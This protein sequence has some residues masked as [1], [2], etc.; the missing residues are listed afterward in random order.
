MSDVFVRTIVLKIYNPSK[1]KKEIL[2]EAMLNYTKAYQYI[3][4]MA[5]NN[6]KFIREKCKDSRGKYNSNFI[7]KWINEKLDKELN[8]FSIEPFKDSIKIDFSTMFVQYLNSNANDLCTFPVAYLEENSFEKAYNNLVDEYFE[9]NKNLDYFE[10]KVDKLLYK[11]EKLRSIFFCRYSAK[12]NYSLLYD[13][14]NNRYYAKIYLMNNK[15]NKRKAG[16]ISS[17]NTLKYID[18]NSEIFKEKLSKKCY[19]VFPL[20]FGKWQEGYLKEALDKPEILK[21]ARLVKRDKDYYLS[22]NIVKDEVPQIQTINYMGISRSFSNAVNYA[23]VDANG[24]CITTGFEN[25][26]GNSIADN[27]LHMIA[28]SLVEMAYEN[29]C[30]LIMEKLVDIGDG[31]KWQER[32]GKSYVPILDYASYNKLYSILKYKAQHRGLPGII[33]VSAVNIFYTCPNCYRISRANRF[34][35]KL[36]ICTSCGKAA[37]V[38]EAGSLN[39]SRKIMKYNKD[40]IKIKVENTGKG[41]KFINK[42]LGFEFYPENPYDCLNEFME[43]IDN[44]IKDFYENIEVESKNSGF[45]KKYSMIKKIEGNKNVFEIIN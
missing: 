18:K 16:S 17:S 15:N 24:E 38:E 30:Q 26:E 7:V 2:D 42:E 4:D 25:I 5:K 8:K 20:C 40:S 44:T 39:L 3:L 1:S 35:G 32:D 11:T 22:I 14:D 37:D 10:E 9:N 33:R 23:I 19:L 34:S 28:N 31:L 6:I 45:K 36:L 41:I 43:Y 13:A 27:K 29:R 12:R 21:T